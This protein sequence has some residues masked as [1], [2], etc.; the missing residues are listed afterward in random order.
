MASQVFDQLMNNAMKRD[1]YIID[2]ALDLE[3]TPYA[4]SH[5]LERLRLARRLD[6]AG[7]VFYRHIAHVLAV[8][9]KARLRRCLERPESKSSKL[10]HF[11]QFML[12]KQSSW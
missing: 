2:I 12:K 1:E 5:I 11:I 6:T 7:A 8:Q 10:L 9:E 3:D 4:G